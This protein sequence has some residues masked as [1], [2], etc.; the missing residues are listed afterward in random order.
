MPVTPNSLLQAAAQAKTQAAANSTAPTA[1]PGDKASSFA[2]V[3]AKQAENKPVAAADGSAK[4]ARETAP[5]TPEK[6]TS[7]AINLPPRNR[8]LPIAAKPCPPINRR[9]A[10]TRPPA[11]MLRMPRRPWL[12]IQRQ[13]TRRSIRP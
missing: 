9:R 4:P 11:I 10:M 2:Q 6:K 13:L 8:R 1:E 5:T 12:P 7:P 3:Y